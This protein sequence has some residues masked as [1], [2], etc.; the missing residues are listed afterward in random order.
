MLCTDLVHMVEIL[1]NC[2]W[3]LMEIEDTE[4]EVIRRECLGIYVKN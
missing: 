2:L 4:L 3:Y 1:K